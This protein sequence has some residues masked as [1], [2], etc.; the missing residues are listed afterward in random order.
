MDI[1]QE[2]LTTFSD[3]PDLL[4]MVITG[5]ESWVYGYDMETNGHTYIH[6]WPLQPFSQDY[7]LAAQTTHVVC[8]SVI[9]VDSE[10]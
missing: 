2:M 7:G 4:K 10:R 5:D 1:A 9:H 3:D 8:V 6:N